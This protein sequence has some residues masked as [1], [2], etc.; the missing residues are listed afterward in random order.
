M[1]DLQ[2]RCSPNEGLITFDAADGAAAGGLKD[3]VPCAAARVAPDTRPIRPNER[4]YIGNE[5]M[6]N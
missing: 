1:E 6:H 3:I 5:G 2:R 4:L